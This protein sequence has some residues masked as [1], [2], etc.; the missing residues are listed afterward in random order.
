MAVIAKAAGLGA[1]TLRNYLPFVPP[2]E[3][4][5]A[6]RWLSGE[7]EARPDREF[8]LP[9]YFATRLRTAAELAPGRDI[10]DVIAA[11]APASSRV[12]DIWGCDVVREIE[13]LVRRETADPERARQLLSAA[14]RHLEWAIGTGGVPLTVAALFKDSTVDRATASVEMSRASA[15]TTRSRLRAL[16]VAAELR[17][18][19]T[20]SS[21]IRH[22]SPY[23]EE[24]LERLVAV[25]PSLGARERRYLES[26]LALGLGVG[27]S[28]R[29]FIEVRGDDIID[30]G[31]LA[32]RLGDRTVF[33]ATAYTEELRRMRGLGGER[34]IGES[35]RAL[36]RVRQRV[37]EAV[38]F[39]VVLSRLR[40]TWLVRNLQLGVP[41]RVIGSA[42][43]TRLLEL[44]HLV[45]TYV[46]VSDA[47]VVSWTLS[48]SGSVPG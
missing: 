38:G 11:F 2:V 10:E 39:P 29:E 19:P 21:A 48:S 5:V 43:G 41:L 42:A 44:S 15:P 28:H 4:A 32:V 17:P 36:K 35:S 1:S 20:A 25:L 14:S 34:L 45:S 18:S 26:A 23:G 30:C 6:A 12:A 13:D 37:D 47:E 8:T 31:T 7:F 9:D 33:A 22:A 40:A 27:A 3:E 46:S 16:S 24:D